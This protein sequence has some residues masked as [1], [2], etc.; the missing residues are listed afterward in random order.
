MRRL[1]VE[2]PA[3]AETRALLR[4]SKVMFGDKAAH[5]YD[6]LMRRAYRLLCA[7]PT[8]A[9]VKRREDLPRA[10]FFFHLRHAR[11]RGMAPRA[12][13]HF[14]V[15]TYDEASLTILRVLHEAMDVEGHAGEDE[16]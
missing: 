15:F 13:R 5:A 3:A 7:D 11:S 6:A 14:I 1:V 8:R 9:G 16:V 2:P 10:P 4:R 12:P